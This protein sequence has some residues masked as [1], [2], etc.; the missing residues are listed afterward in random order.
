LLA[1]TQRAGELVS[2][3]HLIEQVWPDTVVEENNLQAQISALRKLL[4]PDLIATIPGRGYR[5]TAEVTQIKPAPLHNGAAVKPADDDVDKPS[6]AVLPFANLGG[7]PEQEYFADGLAED[8]IAGLARSRWLFVIARNSSFA[9]RKTDLSFRDVARELDVRYV[10]AG[11][12]RRAGE[13]L[14]VSAELV[15]GTSNETVWTRRFDRP[16]TDLFAV[17]DEISSTIASTIEPVYLRHEETRAIAQP[18]RDLAHWQLL[19]RARWHF[20]RLTHSHVVEARRLLEQSLLVKPDDSSSLALLAFTHLADAWGGQTEQ[21]LHAIDLAIRL[22]L[23]AVRNDDQ[24]SHA[25]LTLGTALSC[26]GRFDE[27]IAELRRAL[28]LYPHFAAAAGEL[29]RLLAFSGRCDEAI[30]Y[31]AKAIRSSPNDPNLSLWLRSQAIACFVAGRP[32]DAV[33]HAADATAK[34]PDWF[35]NHYLLAACHSAANDPARARTAIAEAQRQMPTYPLSA[36]I[37]GH[38]F[39]DPTHLYNFIAALRQAGWDG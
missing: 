34:R 4:G 35:F 29:G 31:A 2:K 39:V 11:S 22:S 20:W 23:D 17:Q 8:I 28:D 6:I 36:L 14:R 9:F 10:V 30:S 19:M 32:E 18:E 7:D 5:F 13:T 12:V 15:D 21:S 26:V 3:D 25:H 24:D 27:A 1:L 16:I 33:R 38:P 37:F